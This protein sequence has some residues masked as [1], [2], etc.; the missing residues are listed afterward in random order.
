[1]SKHLEKV[2]SFG[3]KVSDGNH[4]GFAFFLQH[5]RASEKHEGKWQELVV[6]V[7]TKLPIESSKKVLKAMIK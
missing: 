7:V 1:M 3:Y 2:I 6:D 4:E 5:L